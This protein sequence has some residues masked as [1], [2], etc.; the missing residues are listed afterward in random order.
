MSIRISPSG[1]INRSRGLFRYWA[2]LLA[3][4][5]LPSLVVSA[6]EIVQLGK[7]ELVSIGYPHLVGKDYGLG[8]DGNSTYSS[9]S[10][11]GEGETGVESRIAFASAAEN[12]IS[13]QPDIDLHC[14]SEDPNVLR[15]CFDIYVQDP[16]LSQIPIPFLTS[17]HAEREGDSVFPTVSRDGKWVVYQSSSEGWLDD[18]PETIETDIYLVDIS[19]LNASW[20]LN[21][22]YRVSM[23][24]GSQEPDFHSGFVRCRYLNASGQIAQDS[25]TID[26]NRAPLCE[27]NPNG[28]ARPD[29]QYGH[30][31]ADAYTDSNSHTYVVFES[32]ATN[33]GENRNGYLKDIFRRQVGDPQTYLLST[34]CRREGSQI[35]YDQPANGESYHPVVVANTDGRFIVFVSRATNL[36][37]ALP[38]GSVFPADNQN[39][40]PHMRRANIYLHDQDSGQTYLISKDAAGYPANRASEYPAVAEYSPTNYGFRI[41]YQSSANN[42]DPDDLNNYTD[43]FL[44]E[45]TPWTTDSIPEHTRLISK[46]SAY[47]DNPTAPVEPANMPSYAPA[48][49]KNGLV[50]SFTSY[51]TNLIDGDT[52]EQCNYDIEG[53]ATTNCPD[54]FARSWLA[55]QTWRVSLTTRGQ[56]AEHNSN[57]S[58]L[59]A[60]GRYVAFASQAD[61]LEEGQ[62][63]PSL[64]VYL[65][66]QGNP[67]GNPNVQPTS[68]NFGVVPNGETRTKTFTVRFLAELE[69]QTIELRE[70]ALGNQYTQHYRIENQGCIATWV[71]DQFCQ[72]TVRFNAPASGEY[73]SLPV[74]IYMQVFSPDDGG[75]YLELD[76]DAATPVV[77][78]QV[79]QP[80]AADLYY[81]GAPV[82]REV[83]VKNSGNVP[84]S[85]SI[86]V[87]YAE[88]NMWFTLQD[89]AK[90]VNMQPGDEAT[91]TLWA[92]STNPAYAD[93][94]DADAEVR[95][96][97]GERTF[98]SLPF[99]TKSMIVTYQPKIE[100]AA[101][102]AQTI[103]FGATGYYTL[104][105]RNNGN[106]GDTL[107]VSFANNEFAMWVNQ[108]DKD[109]LVNLQPGIDINIKVWV[110]ATTPRHFDYDAKVV[111]T[112]QGD[113]TK[114]D[115]WLLL[116]TS[117]DAFIYL[118]LVRR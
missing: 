13:G 1:L 32:M 96:T 22:P 53:Q 116:S 63:A 104:T 40:P 34:G 37:C 42:I 93:Y 17:L 48:I 46:P 30:P 7:T 24:A 91:L 109:R 114:Q 79:S 8:Q 66:D 70:Q 56:Q 97:S 20:N 26:W 89:Q 77:E 57:Y 81:Q 85:F 4:L 43:I 6:Q 108:S 100:D 113:P 84:T 61:M 87:V 86:D 110:R 106:I 41:A 52:N 67:P 54:I 74:K 60:T 72:F 51:A 47:V 69:V 59:S 19:N 12:L 49:T 115:D 76:L 111:I 103:P 31:V 18:N 112:S 28:T 5:L 62:G 78:G 101:P 118:P 117:G 82:G 16:L 25:S 50:I 9:V 107:N 27:T 21:N 90:L 98:N 3:L 95:L 68:H 36:D 102:P 38:A 73:R 23:A 2:L 105:V 55:Y 92:Q 88:L 65:R 39:D 45:G 58:S 44:Y 71:Q 35:I 94:E 29:L 80:E 15:N 99:F 64:Q 75:R 14:R 83:V 11:Y 10:W 33:L